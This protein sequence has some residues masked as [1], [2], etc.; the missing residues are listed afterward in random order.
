MKNLIYLIN[1]NLKKIFEE[2]QFDTSNAFLSVSK[3]Q[4]LC[5]YQLNASFNLSKTLKKNPMDVANVLIDLIK[6]IKVFDIKVFSKIE[7]FNPGFI[8][9]TLNDE[10]LNKYLYNTKLGKEFDFNYNDGVDK[11]LYDYGG[12][13]VAKPL[14]V[15][16]LRVANIGE[17]LKRISNK[18][19]KKTIS[20]VHLGDFGLQMGLVIEE[21]KDENMVDNFTIRDLEE[22]YPRASKRAKGDIKS[23]IEKDEDF[24]KRAHIATNAIQNDKEPYISIWKKI[25]DVSVED[26]KKRY[27]ELNVNFDYYF[28]EST[29]KNL[30]KPMLDDLKAKKIAVLDD[31]AYVI[32]VHDDND[33]K[34]VPPCI[35]E[36]NDGTI[37]YA[38]TD[39]A[40]ILYRE[41]NFNCDEYVYVVD[42]RQTLHFTQVFRSAKLGKLIDENKKLVHVQVGTMNNTDGTPF[43][44]RDGGVLKLEDLLNQVMDKT[45]NILISNVENI[46]KDELNNISKKIAIS[47]IKYADLSSEPSRDYIFDIDKFTSFQGNTGPYILYTVVRIKSILEKYDLTDEKLLSFDDMILNDSEDERNVIHNMKILSMNYENVV[48]DAYKNYDP[49]YICKYMYDVADSFNKFY[50]EYKILGE[51]NKDYQ[52]YL[53]AVCIVIKNILMDALNLLAIDCPDKM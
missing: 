4:D 26:L 47:A 8:N 19:N 16:H 15:G 12:A 3:R 43:K 6:D 51:K 32:D 28:G 46:D 38:T 17:A 29:V 39:L 53:I 33:K 14:H 24:E 18:I 45:K 50:H 48:I 30:L 2:N 35:V 9:I 36:K 27:G 13:N 20:D 5:D 34:E 42:K 31:G 49:S 11:I 25:I 52:K 37:L 10:L 23:G 21:L 1:D 40:T 22:V 7:A 41:K 44:T